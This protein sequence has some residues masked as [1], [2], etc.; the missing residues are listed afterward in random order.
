TAIGGAP[1]PPDRT[2]R[3][4][5]RADD[6]AGIDETA[7]D[8]GVGP[9]VAD[10]PPPPRPTRAEVDRVE[11]AVL[12]EGVDEPGGDGGPGDDAAGGSPVRPPG[13]AGTGVERQQVPLLA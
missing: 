10:R 5:E 11:D 6:A 7:G 9:A 12:G 2:G 4:V 3:G 13:G 8:D 1:A